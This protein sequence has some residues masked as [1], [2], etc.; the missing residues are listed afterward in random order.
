M[1]HSMNTYAGFLLDADNTIFDYDRSEKE[2]LIETCALET[3][4]VPPAKMVETY[5]SINSEYWRR[6]EKGLIG[7]A[8]LQVGRFD[9]LLRAV[10]AKADARRVSDSYLDR[11]SR[12]A[13]FVP[14]A[15]EVLEA[16]ASRATLAV[17]TNGISRVQRGRL[18]TA[19]ISSLFK[20]ILISEEVGCAKP[21]PRY[22]QLAVRAVGLD[23]HQLLCVGD[24]PL[25]DI[26]GARAAGIDACWFN[27]NR[28]PWPGPGDEPTFVASDLREIVKY[29]VGVFQ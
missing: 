17:I 5:R 23:T 7:V 3:P 25:A 28:V 14:H 4:D 16:L 27:P 6:F 24:N 13:Y 20:A 29:G 26:A 10:G 12:K 18:E 9:E 8:E 11:L 22:F 19:G 15:R 21:D 2:A 1:T